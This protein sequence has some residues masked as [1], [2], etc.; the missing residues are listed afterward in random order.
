MGGELRGVKRGDVWKH[1]FGRWRWSP[2]SLFPEA[3]DETTPQAR[4]DNSAVP[5]LVH[6]SILC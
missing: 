6:R 2:K 1:R 3:T 4:N 5:G